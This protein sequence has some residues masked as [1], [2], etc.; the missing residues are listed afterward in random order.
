VVLARTLRQID[1][2]PLSPDAFRDA[3][4]R[5]CTANDPAVLAAVFWRA[6]RMR[7]R[8]TGRPKETSGRDSSVQKSLEGGVRG[9]VGGKDRRLRGPS[10]TDLR[11]WL[12]QAERELFVMQ[13]SANHG[14]RLRPAAM[15]AALVVAAFVVGVLGIGLTRDTTTAASATSVRAGSSVANP[16]VVDT[17]PRKPAVVRAH[18][19]PQTIQ[20]KRPQ[21]RAIA[22]PVPSVVRARTVHMVN[23][24]RSTWAVVR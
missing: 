10:S 13:A 22:P 3:L 8:R 14:R 18:S 21:K 7:P 12:R 1:L 2:P 17:L 9:A 11:H 5:F 23:L 4:R 16:I 15:A 24:P 20:H 19:Q 6:A